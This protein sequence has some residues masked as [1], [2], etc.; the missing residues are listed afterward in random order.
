M[1]QEEIILSER[2]IDYMYHAVGLDHNRPKRGV[3]RLPRNY[4]D[5]GG[6]DV[7]VWNNL[8][9][10]GLA[11]YVEGVYMVSETGLKLIEK[12]ILAKIKI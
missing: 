8:V 3:Y 12:L 9:A 7:L 10:K 1:E 4:Y 2:E 6:N 5:A 11:R